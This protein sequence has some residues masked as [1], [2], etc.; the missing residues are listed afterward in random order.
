MEA[1]N[2]ILS[3]LYKLDHTHYTIGMEIS[4]FTQ[5]KIKVLYV[6]ESFSTGVYAIVRDI[7]CNLDSNR[8]TVLIL[9]SLRNDSPKNYEQDFD[10]THITLQYVP[11]GTSKDYIKAIS[12]IRQAI[13]TFQPHAI[14]LHSSK[15]G[16]LG[17]IAAKGSPCK[18]ILYS[19]HGFSFLRTDVGTL[20]RKIFFM[21]EYGINKFN[22]SKFIAVSEGELVHAH[23]ITSNAIVINNFIDLQDFN[24]QLASTKPYIVTTGR[25]SAQK[26]PLLFNAIAEQ[27]PELQFIWVGDGPQREKLTAP[28]ITITGLLS[29]S[30]AIS[31]VEKS[32][33]YIQ[34]SL[35]EG[36]PVSIL[37]AMAS[38][39]SVVATDIIG[40]RDL[41][42]HNKTGFLCNPDDPKQF[43]QLVKTLHENDELRLTIGTAAHTYIKNNHDKQQ[44]IA[45]YEKEYASS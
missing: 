12:T 29:R 36:M 13:K 2:E 25:I 28:N 1:E 43:I 9:H 16:L 5:E 32:E 39:K 34:T 11:M 33:I 40:N 15:A 21:L 35:W 31:F 7:A 41:I 18:H 26:N 14:H 19:P 44:A 20:A 42:T 37:E 30:E 22:K 4:S 27:L 17:R 6:V 45:R 10:T 23:E 24:K 3:L 38:G 8:F